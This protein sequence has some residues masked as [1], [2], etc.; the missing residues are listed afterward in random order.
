MRILKR[1]RFA[2]LIASITGVSLL[3]VSGAAAWYHYSPQTFPLPP[4]AR[5]QAFD[6]SSNGRPRSTSI[7]TPEKHPSPSPTM[8]ES[9][10]TATASSSASP[11]ETTTQEAALSETSTVTSTPTSTPSPTPP[12]FYTP[13]KTKSASSK[14]SPTKTPVP[15]ATKTAKPP[16]PSPTATIDPATATHTALPGTATKTPT[17]SIT[18]TP[19]MTPTASLTATITDTLQPSRTPTFT[20]TP[21]PPTATQQGPLPTATVDLSGCGYATHSSYERELLTLINNVRKQNGV[22]PLSMQ[23]Q[24]R[25]AAREHSA[26]MVCN[27]QYSHTGSNGTTS[28]DRI[29]AYGYSPTF[30]GENFYVG[31]QTTPQ[32]AFNWWMN[33]TP[34]RK[35][36]L[37]ANYIHIGIGHGYYDNRN[38]YT[39]NFGRP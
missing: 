23:S 6:P 30:W 25:A 33:S 18:P 17:A 15:Y 10:R 31:W 2:S 7:L 4:V 35:N 13:T 19:S 5:Q 37:S 34:H 3:I 24:L 39:L 38:G 20:L 16:T 36:I 8:P 27:K 26:D 28:Y 1:I 32:E 21:K 29:T 22:S 9:S 11:A 12:P 14:S